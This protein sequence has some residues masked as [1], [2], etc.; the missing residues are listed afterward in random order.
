[1]VVLQF[2]NFSLVLLSQSFQSQPKVFFFLFLL[3]LFFLVFL[4]C[5]EHEFWVFA[6]S[7]LYRVLLLVQQ[8]STFNFLGVRWLLNLPQQRLFF[9]GSTLPIRLNGLFEWLDAIGALLGGYVDLNV[10][11][12]AFALLYVLVLSFQLLLVGLV[13]LHQLLLS[14][15]LLGKL[16]LAKN[17]VI[18]FGVPIS[19]LKN[20]EHSVGT[21]REQVLILGW[22]LEASDCFWM[23][24]NLINA[25]EGQF[26]D[27]NWTWIR[28]VGVPHA[29]K[30]TLSRVMHGQLGQMVFN[31][32]KA[33]LRVHIVHCFYFGHDW[34]AGRENGFLVS[35]CNELIRFVWQVGNGCKL[36][37]LTSFVLLL[38]ALARLTHQVKEVDVSVEACWRE[39][40]VIFEP[41]DWAYNLRVCS[42]VGIN[43][44]L[45]ARVKIVHVDVLFARQSKQM[46]TVRKADFMTS[47][48]CQLL[49]R[50][51]GTPQNVEH[52]DLVLQGDDQMQ[53]GR[54]ERHSVTFFGEWNATLVRTS[55]IIPHSQR[56]VFRTGHEELF[57]DANIQTG[58]F[59]LVKRPS[60]V[61]P[62]KFPAHASI[63]L[64]NIWVVD[65]AWSLNEL[66][67]GSYR[68]HGIFVGVRGYC[69]DSFRVCEL[70]RGTI[71]RIQ[72]LF[73]TDGLFSNSNLENSIGK[74]VG[75]P[76]VLPVVAENVELALW[77][78]KEA[79]CDGLDRVD[80]YAPKG[81]LIDVVQ[82]LAIALAD[83]HF[84]VGCADQDLGGVVAPGMTGVICR[85]VASLLHIVDLGVILGELPTDALFDAQ[86]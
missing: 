1:M 65:V 63:Q 44:W 71:V 84:S 48:H 64:H 80:G 50:L 13:I 79:V 47:L 27:L 6:A 16:E 56:F 33:S 19:D 14:E 68:K 9:G 69:K 66:A 36:H 52:P 77:A 51:Y 85:N 26:P 32:G 81:C 54:V 12:I 7:F 67:C 60:H 53:A 41:V 18:S 15:D 3:M 31:F 35:D 45:I 76:F 24:L 82:I 73:T 40:H 83:N 86:F 78:D 42:L 25:F 49:V 22:K 5:L 72:S 57:A 61:V 37:V 28:L 17:W 59:I 38:V 58:Y 39:S 34:L 55:R 30:E 4:G 46:T 62:P 23:R 21:H 2:S 29:C 20:A 11:S 74:F 70:R 8:F 75:S 43:G 10:N